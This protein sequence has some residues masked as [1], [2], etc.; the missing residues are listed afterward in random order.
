MA[1]IN[2]NDKL[3]LKI[4]AMTSDGRGIARTDTDFVIFVNHAIPGDLVNAEIKKTGRNFAEASITDLVEESPFRVKPECSHFGICNGCKLQNTK[5]EY[6]LELKSQNV[7]DAF[8]RI[9]GFKDLLITDVIGSDNIYFYRNKIEF[10]FS[11]NRWLT[12]E[13]LNANV[14]DKH[15]ALGFHMPNYIDKVLDITKCYLQS[16]VS[17][18]ILNFTRD[19]FKIRNETIYSTKTHTGYLRFLVIRQS[20]S[21][22]ELLVNII[23][24]SENHKLICEYSEA[25]K[26]EIPQVTTLVNT[27]STAKAQVAQG[28]YLI[29]IYGTGYI[30]ESINNFK[31]KITPGSFFQTNSLQ[32]K[33]LFEYVTKLANF[34]K[35]D[36]VLDLYCGAGAISIFIS[37]FVEHVTGVELS[38]ESIV[39]ARENCELNQIKN[40]EFISFDV[41]DY[42]KSL[43][44]SESNRY[45]IFVLDPPR[46][47]LH[48]K[49]IEYI[50]QYEPNKIIYVSCNPST[51][52]RDVKLLAEKYNI[53]A[54]QPID[55][56]P[57]TFHI[58][59]I[60]RLDLK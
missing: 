43:I 16:D 58:E 6:Q 35:N 18:K 52:A 32:A 40:C 23:T 2:K 3:K 59:N 47:G 50:N 22:N 15:F 12:I 37:G 55:M 19:F 30:T 45:N 33:N 13:D 25:L 10:S 38:D 39:N 11:N 41:K 60:V 21:T 42:L 26:K 7:K 20:C 24:S 28:D 9:G 36:G 14:T 49:A 1:G 46:S 4:S 57:Q 17:N 8:E 53:T 51:Q 5:Y 48:P 56:F 34:S 44:N 31:F 27:I 29:T 54:I